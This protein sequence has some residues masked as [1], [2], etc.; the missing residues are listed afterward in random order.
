MDYVYFV[1]ERQSGS[2]RIKI[3]ATGICPY[4]RLSQLRNSMPKKRLELVGSITVPEEQDSYCQ[5]VEKKLH[6]QFED[7]RGEGEWF[8]PGIRLLQYIQENA[9]PHFCNR[10]CP[11]GPSSEEEMRARD[12]AA[13]AG[14]GDLI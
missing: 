6:R 9:R 10:F 4:L 3:G 13:S 1:Q 2:Y 7:L 8:R 5:T 14:V 12:N 11:D